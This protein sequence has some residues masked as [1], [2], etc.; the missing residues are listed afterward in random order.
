ME[1]GMIQQMRRV[2]A[3][4]PKSDQDRIIRTVFDAMLEHPHLSQFER[5]RLEQLRRELSRTEARAA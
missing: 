5:R 4:L 1:I 3:H 2:L